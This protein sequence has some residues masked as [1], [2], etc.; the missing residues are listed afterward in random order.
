MGQVLGL[1]RQV[2]A[3]LGSRRSPRRREG[4]GA[5]RRPAQAGLAERRR[6]LLMRRHPLEGVKSMCRMPGLTQLTSTR[7]GVPRAPHELR[8][9]GSPRSRSTGPGDA[10]AHRRRR[11]LFRRDHRASCL[12]QAPPIRLRR[13]QYLLGPTRINFDPAALWALVRTVGVYPAGSVL[14][15]DSVSRAVLSPNPQDVR[16]PNCRVLVRPDGTPAEENAV[17]EWTP[18][19]AERSVTRV[20]KPEEYASP[21]AEHLAA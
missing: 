5:G 7:C 2:L 12:P 6:V 4:R 14:H 11:G 21:T 8:P 18:M 10:L 3:D 9:D 19:P 13:V 1:P 17:E 16:R 20:L 15:L